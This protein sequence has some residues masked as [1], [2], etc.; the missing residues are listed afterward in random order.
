MAKLILSKAD[1]DDFEVSPVK[2]FVPNCGKCSLRVVAEI[3]FILQFAHGEPFVLA[4]TA[5]IVHLV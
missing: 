4:S 5:M 1:V 3:W 2:C